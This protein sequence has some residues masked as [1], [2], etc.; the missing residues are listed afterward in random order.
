MLESKIKS[1]GSL[2]AN[3]QFN[4]VKDENFGFPHS[5]TSAVL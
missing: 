5:I 2:L 1:L 3:K 4:Q